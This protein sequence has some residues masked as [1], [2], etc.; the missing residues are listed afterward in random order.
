MQVELQYNSL[1]GSVCV[2]TSTRQS[3]TT[4]AFTSYAAAYSAVYN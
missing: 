4:L 1:Y 3:I 2:K